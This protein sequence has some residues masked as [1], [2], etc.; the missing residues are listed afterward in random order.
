MPT[1]V[2]AETAARVR[3][4]VLEAV[5]Q[6]CRAE[7]IVVQRLYGG[8]SNC[9]YR[10]DRARGAAAGTPADAT[11]VVRVIGTGGSVLVDRGVEVRLCVRL[12]AAGRCPAVHGIFD[13]GYVTSFVPGRALDRA[14]CLAHRDDVARELARW[15]AVDCA[16]ALGPPRLMLW[17]RVQHWAHLLGALPRSP[18]HDWA[19]AAAALDAELAPLAA[20]LDAVGARLVRGALPPVVVCHNDVNPTNIMAD[21]DPAG[22]PRNPAAPVVFIDLEYAFYN[23]PLFDIAHHFLDLGGM[24]LDPALV[25]DPAWQHAFLRTYLAQWA[26]DHPRGE[27]PVPGGAHRPSHCSGCGCGCGDC[28]GYAQVDG[29][30]NTS[31]HADAGD[32]VDEALL[33]DIAEAAE[34]W[35]LAVHLLW[36]VWALFSA[37]LCEH[38]DSTSGISHDD[39]F[40]FYDF[41][42]LRFDRY[43]ATRLRLG[44]APT[45]LRAYTHSPDDWPAPPSS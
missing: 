8:I 31:A 21:D 12:G 7:D 22:R 23:N 25:P 10:C 39:E 28:G 36:G 9:I 33:A 29:A 13:G 44:L 2:D 6:W 5:P 1:P 3:G 20:H 41:A 37:A 24:E 32:G 11:L 27:P 18:R 26:A 45:P 30:G 34:H 35:Q 14:G 42:Q 17:A 40:D 15:H 43:V 4:F 16:A 38:K 19:A